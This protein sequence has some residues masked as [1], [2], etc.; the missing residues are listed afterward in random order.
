MDRNQ[1]QHIFSEIGISILKN[2]NFIR[3][4][5]GYYENFNQIEL[6]GEQWVFFEMNF[7][8]RPRPKKENK[9]TFY[10]ETEAI[11]YFFLKTLKKEYASSKI[12]QTNKSVSKINSIEGLK[13]YF[14]QVGI[15]EEYYSMSTTK[16]Q[17]LYTEII[18]NKIIVSYLDENKQKR[19]NTIPLEVRRGIFVMY[20]LTYGFYL[21]KKIEKEFIDKGIL[22]K[23][24][25]DEDVEVFIK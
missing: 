5:K 8:Q 20:K 11:N 19:F 22:T 16:P 25:T 3:E 14:Q 21:L 18:D 10:N 7:E 9:K 17:I 15:P 1:L 2:D 4:D 13:H 12:H 6:D 23:N 24:F